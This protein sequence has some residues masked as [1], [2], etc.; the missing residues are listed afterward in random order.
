MFFY[1]EMYKEGWLVV[2]KDKEKVETMY[3]VNYGGQ[4]FTQSV[5]YNKR[6][7]EDNDYFKAYVVA[8]R[9]AGYDITVEDN[10]EDGRHDGAR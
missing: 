7:W 3:L 8:L 4:F 10:L 6:Q 2:G 9:E 5:Q 1:D